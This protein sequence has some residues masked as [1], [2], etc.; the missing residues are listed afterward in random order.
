[1]NFKIIFG[2]DAEDYVGIEETELEKAYY[3]FLEKKDSIF[4]GGAVRGSNI[5]AIQPD[6]HA[7]MGWNRGH[8]LGGDDYAELKNKGVDR[9]HMTYLA[10]AKSHVQLL[11]QNGQT[12]L[13]G[14]ANVPALPS[15]P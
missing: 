7:A 10:G 9:K 14:K 15:T 13:I 6:Y 12:H 5:M 1:M 2:Y 3:C 11:I 8:K 4:S